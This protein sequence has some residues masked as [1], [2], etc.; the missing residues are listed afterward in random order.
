MNKYMKNCKNYKVLRIEFGDLL[1]IIIIIL[2]GLYGTLHC[3]A[4]ILYAN[5]DFFCIDHFLP[6]LASLF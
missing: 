2:L 6:T 4:M 5:L 1:F 3:A